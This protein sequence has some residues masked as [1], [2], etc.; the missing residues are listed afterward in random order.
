MKLL[1][2]LMMIDMEERR[3]RQTPLLELVVMTVMVTIVVL[4]VVAVG[5]GN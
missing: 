3:I 1:L 4:V 5:R 2:Q